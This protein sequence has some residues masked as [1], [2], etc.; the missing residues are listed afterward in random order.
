MDEVELVILN[1]IEAKVARRPQPSD[2]LLRVGIDS[3]AMAEIALEIDELTYGAEHPK[4]A[5]IGD[6]IAHVSQLRRNQARA[7]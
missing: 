7:R 3:L 6:L 5:T 4:V 2:D 1:S